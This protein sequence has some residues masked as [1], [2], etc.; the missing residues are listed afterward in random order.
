M[1][2]ES[3]G[4]YSA[5][6]L[7]ASHRRAGGRRCGSRD[8]ICEACPS[9]PL[10]QELTTLAGRIRT[11]RCERPPSRSAAWPFRTMS[12]RCRDGDP[13]IA[14]QRLHD[15]A[16]H[17]IRRSVDTG[18]SDDPEIR[19]DGPRVRAPAR[20]PLEA[21]E[22]GRSSGR[23]RLRVLTGLPPWISISN[24]TRSLRLRTRGRRSIVLRRRCAVVTPDW[25]A[26][27]RSAAASRSDSQLWTVSTTA[28]ST[29]THGGDSR[30]ER[31]RGIARVRRISTNPDVA[32]YLRSA[33]IK[34][35]TGVRSCASPHPCNADLPVRAES[36]PQ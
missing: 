14:R 6:T 11:P 16:D 21:H 10:R 19:S 4:R 5:E 35:S 15:Q 33:G 36:L 25:H 27:V 29:V 28:C 32:R 24:S 18:R 26:W 3:F 17:R 23:R 1:I 30:G 22:L 34:I 2:V 13:A 31:V 8:R 12:P 20:V 7:H 9:S